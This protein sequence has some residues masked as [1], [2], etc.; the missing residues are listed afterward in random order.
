VDTTSPYAVTWNAPAGSHT[1]TAAA[2]DNLGAMTT[3]GAVHVDVTPLAGRTNVALAANGGVATASS[4]LGVKYPAAATTNGDRKGV[5][6]GNGGGWNDGTA[7]ASPD[8]M[9]VS[10]NGPKLIEQVDVFSMQDNYSS[11]A[12]PTASMT[13]TSWGLRAFEIQYWDGASWLTI[14]GASV[15]ANSLVWRQ[16]VF[17]PIATSKI[18]VFITG[19]L[20]GY[21]RMMEV[22]AWGVPASGGP[23]GGGENDAPIITI[24][25]PAEGATFTTPASVTVTADASDADGSI[26]SVAFYANTTLI[27][28]DTTAPFSASW[29]NMA[30][31]SYTLT[32]VATDDLG[33]LTTSAGVHVTVSV[34]PNRINHALAAN[35]AVATASSTYT[36]KYPASGTT[37][38]DRKGLNWGNGGGWNDGT[39]YASPDWIEIAFNGAKTIDEV[40]VFSMQD[41]YSAPSEPTPTLTFTSW[42]LRAFEVQ[43]WNGTA[44]V[45][46]PG[47]SVTNN[48]LVWRKLVFSA[49]TTTKIRVWITAALNGYSRVMEVEAWGSTSN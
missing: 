30:A 10:F 6:W 42:G 29:T 48:N 35:G 49:V 39:A 14:P 41:N 16:F 32:A 23:P 11:P 1:L 20:N 19:A 13:F 7:Y 18:R 25:S 8:W 4:I 44:W 9:E 40:G 17:V 43:Y 31:G 5:N 24:T 33:E 26:A 3:S 12:E 46:I 21:S 22:E 15:T 2:T 47:A 36:P 34:N 45:S 37:N 27:G 28:T 38:G